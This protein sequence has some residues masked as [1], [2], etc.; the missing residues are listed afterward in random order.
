MIPKVIY[1]S[2]FT[3][4]LPS[5]VEKS[6]KK[7]IKDNP[8]YE[9]I[10]YTDAQI[11]DYVNANFEKNITSAFNSLG[12]IVPKVDFWR[13]LILYRNG[14]VYVDIDSSINVP[15]NNIINEND[16][17]I[18]SAENNDDNF[19]QWAL[20]FKKEHPILKEVIDIVVHNISNNLY[21]NYL[22]NA[23]DLIKLTAG[24]AFTKAIKKIHKEYLNKEL[25]WGEIDNSTDILYK[26]EKESESFNYRLLGKD[27]NGKL[28]WKAK[29][30]Y[31]LY[32]MKQHWLK[33]LDD[34]SL[35]K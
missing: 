3:Q 24:G 5:K 23:E 25:I 10:I 6:V 33:D 15:L 9:H 21:P 11:H 1:R 31:Q 27:F 2:W 29:E 28:S 34:N 8:S 26:Y 35:R 14:G 7:L 4:N 32:E 18:I 19:V 12:H 30:S 22:T 13:Y 16:E 20:F 17:A